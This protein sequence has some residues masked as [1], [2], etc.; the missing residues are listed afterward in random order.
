MMKRICTLMAVWAAACLSVEARTLKV[1]MIGNSFS[2]SVLKQMPAVARAT[3]CELDLANLY[4]GGCPLNAHWSNVEKAAEDPEARPYVVQLSWTS[5]A[6]QDA[7]IQKVMKGGRANIPQAL[8]ADRWDVVTVQQASHESAFY[9]KYQ[10]YADNLIA[11]IRELAPQAEI[12]VHETWS[13]SPYDGRLTAWG[14]TL[15]AM[16]A[17]LH[18]AY[19]TL[20]RKHCLKI[21]PTGTAVQLYRTRRPVEWKNMPS[22]SERAALRPPAPLPFFGDPVGRASWSKSGKLQVDAFHL[23]PAGEYLQGCVWVAA[24]FGKDVTACTYAPPGLPEKDAELMRI[25]A[26]EAV[27]GGMK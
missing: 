27:S 8:A 19:A 18:E 20:A 9:G 24:L 1:L 22:A 26:W 13:Y 14:L 2:E 6:V 11:K 3:G 23:N 4:I 5:C 15:D 7:P 17:K 16:Y 10:P 25:C 21:I 12:R